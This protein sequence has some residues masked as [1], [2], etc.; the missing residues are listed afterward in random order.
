MYQL[1]HYCTG[2]F[3][4]VMC[5]VHDADGLALLCS[6]CAFSRFLLPCVHVCRCSHFPHLSL[7]T[8]LTYQFPS[9]ISCRKWSMQPLGVNCFDS[10]CMTIIS[11]IACVIY[12]NVEIFVA[13]CSSYFLSLV[14]VNKNS[15]YCNNVIIIIVV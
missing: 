2:N 7:F 5:P 14:F 4:K 12:Y 8:S 15:S 11:A 13:I 3:K 6:T 9:P 10:T 1:V